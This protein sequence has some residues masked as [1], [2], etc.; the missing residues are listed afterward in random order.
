MAVSDTDE[1][2]IEVRT[3][4]LQSNI[5]FV[6]LHYG[7]EIG[8][9]TTLTN[10]SG[11]N[12]YFGFNIGSFPVNTT[13]YYYIEVQDDSFYPNTLIDNNSGNYYSMF[14]GDSDITPPNIKTPI[15]PTSPTELTTIEI[16]VQVTDLGRGVK[17]VKLV[18]ELDGSNSWTTVSMQDNDGDNVYNITLS[19][20]SKGTMINYYIVATDLSLNNNSALLDNGGNYYILNIGDSDINGPNINPNPPTYS[21]T[22]PSDTDQINITVLV[23]DL[24]G[25]ASVKLNYT[26][27]NGLSWNL[28]SM[29]S[30]GNGYYSILIGP[31]S[32]GSQI[33]F[34]II[35]EDNSLNQNTTESNENYIAVGSS[36][37]NV[38]IVINVKSVQPTPLDT[39]FV[40]IE[41]FVFDNSGIESVSLNYTLNNGSSGW[42]IMYEN[43]TST[44]I[45]EL[46]YFQAGTVITYFIHAKDASLNH[47]EKI[48]QNYVLTFL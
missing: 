44:Y 39:D 16:Q 7:T 14:V 46:G 21:P 34:Y 2:F 1:I 18:Y 12:D 8:V 13:I 24:S 47:N 17:W 23:T 40:M 10:S 5:Q 4:D 9:W 20:F 11:V 6:K 27:N 19:T 38:P 41:A 32:A 45:A 36:D 37:A 30:I 15:Q 43:S 3:V 48:T 26:T 29:N 28:N 25:I 22:S 42:V 31:F 35:A 33:I